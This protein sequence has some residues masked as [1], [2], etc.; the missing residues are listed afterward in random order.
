MRFE[1]LALFGARKHV[2]DQREI[3]Q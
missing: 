3:E 2:K 1:N